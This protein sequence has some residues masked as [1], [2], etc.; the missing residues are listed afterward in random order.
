MTTAIPQPITPDG[1]T[2]FRANQS[3]GGNK[4]TDLAAPSAAN[5]AARK[6][7]V[8]N[9][10]IDTA[11]LADEAVTLGKMAHIAQHTF[12]GRVTSG[13]GDVEALVYTSLTTEPTP[14]SGDFLIGFLSTGE[15]IK[16]DVST[17]P[18]GAG[19]ETNT[20]S[21][22]GAG[23]SVYSGK[24]GVDLELH[25]VAAGNGIGVSLVTEDVTIAVDLATDPGL[26]FNSGSIRVLVDPAGALERVTAGLDVADNGIDNA[27]LAQAA[28]WTLKGNNTASTANVTD[29]DLASLTAEL[30]PA[31]GD[32]FLLEKSTGEFRKV[33][34]DDMP[35]ASG[36]ETNTASNVGGGV[37]IFSQKTGVDFEFHSLVAASG[38]TISLDG[39]N[40]EIDVAVNLAANPGLEFSSSALR[41]LVDP[42][43]ALTRSAAGLDVGTATINT[44]RLAAN[45]V[46]LA[47]IQQVSTGTLLGRYNAATGA[48]ESFQLTDLTAETSP[49]A[50]DLVLLELAAG[51]FRKVTY[52]N[53]A[54]GS[55]GINA[56]SPSE[57]TVATGAITVTGNFHTVD[58]ESDA[59]SDDLDTIN[60]GTAGDV[61]Y[62]QAENSGRDVTV[63]HNVGNVLLPGGV[64]VT[65][66]T[67]GVL[68]LVY[69][70]TNWIGQLAAS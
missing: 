7:D 3:M 11:N 59:A 16:V 20:A 32:F 31:S 58:T 17:L 39:P 12:L 40:D 47:K 50:S 25:G 8:D 64:G 9:A 44:D 33:D 29:F 43:G 48:V 57:L 67:D 18:T 28:A 34:Y 22:V 38:I 69:D 53:L 63:T 62:L 56:G 14:T 61:L 51:G 60:G 42:S 35:G 46:T 41:V 54:A 24:T 26:E 65:L 68:Q 30:T 4:L 52:S 13:S 15:L 5:D 70:G 1:A 23:V 6:T 66:S 45:A 19:G 55:G 36:G 10:S 49:S 21:N 2:D 37:G 27:R